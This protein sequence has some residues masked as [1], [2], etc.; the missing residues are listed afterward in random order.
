MTYYRN[1]KYRAQVDLEPFKEFLAEYGKQLDE[2]TFDGQI[3]KDA[4]YNFTCLRFSA[5]IFTESERTVQANQEPVKSEVAEV[6]AEA[7][8][9][10]ERAQILSSVF[11][12]NR[13][14][15]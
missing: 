15:K 14:K 11:R 1:A 5:S 9:L 8:A 6:L 13:K 10:I 3:W 4:Q 2:G 7:D 12:G